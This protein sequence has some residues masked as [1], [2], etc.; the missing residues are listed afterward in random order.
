ML[1][2]GGGGIFF[3]MLGLIAKNTFKIKNESR[4][5]IETQFL[6]NKLNLLEFQEEECVPYI[7]SVVTLN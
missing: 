4:S 5:D 6:K 2:R 7:V 1:R 3:C